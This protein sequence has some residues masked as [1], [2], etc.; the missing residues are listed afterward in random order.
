[1]A[2]AEKASCSRRGTSSC[3]LPTASSLS[4]LKQVS[5]LQGSTE[6]RAR[7]YPGGIGG[8]VAGNSPPITLH[9]LTSPMLQLP[10]NVKGKPYGCHP[11]QHAPEP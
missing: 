3:L 4:P 7:E 10:A 1:M 5:A 9:C 11:V 2:V 6:R 8:D